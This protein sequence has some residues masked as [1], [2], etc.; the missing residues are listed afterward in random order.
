MVTELPVTVCSC[1]ICKSM[2]DRPCW[3]TPEEAKKLIEA[4]LAKKLMLDYW[5]GTENTPDIDLISPAVIGYEAR[6]A[7]F[8]PSGKCTFFNEKGLCDI[9]HM[10]P[11]EGRIADCKTKYEEDTHY[12]VACLWNTPE[13]EAVV[14]LWKSKVNW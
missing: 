14:A 6:K 4:G 13:G 9:H 1:D 2:C 8:F 11:L 10:K 12:N 3:P 5:C 7:P